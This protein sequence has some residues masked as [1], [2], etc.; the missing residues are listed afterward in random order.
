M[1]DIITGCI[2]CGRHLHDEC[3]YTPCCCVKYGAT[4]TKRSK[5]SVAPSLNP[6]NPYENA[7]VVTGRP[8]KL[9]ED[10][11]DPLSTGRKRAAKLYPIDET[12]PCDWRLKKNCGGGKRPIVGCLDGLQIHIHHGPDKN[13]LNNAETNV[14]RICNK[15]HNRW[16]YLNDG[17]YDDS[18]KLNIHNPVSATVDEVILY[19][20]DW[21]T[22]KFK[23][24]T[25][26]RVERFNQRG[27]KMTMQDN[28]KANSP[29][30]VVTLDSDFSVAEPS[31][32]EYEKLRD[33]IVD[34]FSVRDSDETDEVD[35]L[36]ETLGYIHAFIDETVC[37]CRTT[38]TDDEEI[39][40]RCKILGR[41]FDQ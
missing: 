5:A 17:D 6:T 18:A 2:A 35:L 19:Q 20:L 40:D 14:H 7:T 28:F 13:P 10:I 23:D 31:D 33:I 37:Y 41:K 11:R 24:I 15:C 21:D 26:M 36:I 38:E 12:A 1:T 9:V 27:K 22:N 30:P 39:C 25:A 29:V 8:Q 32:S 4:E 34:K 16:H 3:I